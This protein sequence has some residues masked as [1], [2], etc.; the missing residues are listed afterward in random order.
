M[1]LV[2]QDTD[3]RFGMKIEQRKLMDIK[4]YESNPRLNDDAVDAVAA[5]LREFGFRQPIVVD[6]DGVIVCGH[7]RYKAAQQLGL[8]KVPV[9]IARDLTPEQIKAYRIADNQTASLAEWNAELLP[10]ELADLQACNYDLRLLGFDADELARWLDPGVLSGECDPD[11][12][13][14]PPDEAI[15]QPGDLWILGD[16]RLLCGDSGKAEDVDRLLGGAAIHMV[17]T[18]PPYNVKALAN[19][20]QRRRNCVPR[21]GRWPTISSATKRLTRCC[22]PGSGVSRA[23][24]CRAEHSTAG[25]ATPTWPTIRRC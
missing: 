22:T 8:A 13:P 3:W 18:D 16:H 11:E 6:T 4:P 9:H 23:C 7:T 14:S 1:I 17:N 21:I 19:R 12:I 20:S 2:A 15:T 24:C 10:L 5:S 25:V